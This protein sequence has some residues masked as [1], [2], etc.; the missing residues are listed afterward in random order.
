MKKILA[1][2]FTLFFIFSCFGCDEIYRQNAPLYTN[3]EAED[4][5]FKVHFIDVGQGECILVEA[6]EHYALFDA[7][8][9]SEVHKAVSYLSAQ[10]VKNLDYV[11]CTHPH[12]DHCGGIPRIM[13]TYEC[14]AL[15]F[16]EVEAD[17]NL[18]YSVLDTADE[19]GVPCITAKSGDVY[20][21]GTATITVLSPSGN[22]IYSNLNDYSLVC[23]VEY[24]NTSVLLTGDAGK[25]VESELL[26][27]G[28]DLGA[29][30]L[31][32]GHHGSSSSTSVEFLK[33]VKPS[34]AVISCGKDNEYGHP[35]RETVDALNKRKI[36]FKT[37]A[38]DG[39]TIISSDGEKL[40]QSSMG[41]SQSLTQSTENSETSYIGNKNS[42]VFHSEFC[43]SVEKTKEKNKVYFSS[44]EEAVEQGFSPCKGCNP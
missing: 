44:R 19:R 30:V 1:L 14:G 41:E 33:A 38:A 3:T 28:L 4:S 5:P 13:R 2:C 36:P 6:F 26:S 9:N 20:S 11:F 43:E 15:L 18:W 27:K 8:E 29:D 23:M 42:M 34:L 24:E 10:G 37:T 17:T 21:L 31:C 39:T 7:G 25:T 22:S 16:P 35:H 40:Y 12:S 32:V